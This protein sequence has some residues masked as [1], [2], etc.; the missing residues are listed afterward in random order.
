MGSERR[1]ESRHRVQ[2]D[3]IHD[4]VTVGLSE[5]ISEHGLRMIGLAEN[6][7]G[8]AVRLHLEIEVGRLLPVNGVVAWKASGDDGIRL[9]IRVEHP[10]PT[11]KAFV[12]DVRGQQERQNEDGPAPLRSAPRFTTIIPARY[13]MRANEEEDCV[14]LDVSPGG[15]Q[16]QGP[17][18]PPAGS[19]VFVKINHP[20]VGTAQLLGRV[21]WRTADVEYPRIGLRLDSADES[22]YRLL[23]KL[24]RP[25]PVP[26][27][28]ELLDGLELEVGAD[29]LIDKS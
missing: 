28:D 18:A 10:S 22:F 5:D 15:V 25:R 29:S 23:T 21:V 26:R 20:D 13:G 3:V 4:L 24:S 12:Q 17:V 11:W 9:A 19:S 6:A 8:Q 14:L 1:Q 2:R 27:R 7:V 16:L